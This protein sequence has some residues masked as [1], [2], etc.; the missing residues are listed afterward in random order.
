M[1][2]PVEQKRAEMFLPHIAVQVEIKADH[3]QCRD[4]ARAQRARASSMA[5]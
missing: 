2:L 4:S 1:H 5:L 3:A